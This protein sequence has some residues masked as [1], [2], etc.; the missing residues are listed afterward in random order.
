MSLEY[1]QGNQNL[2]AVTGIID[3]YNDWFGQVVTAVSY[4][5]ENNITDNVH[6][7]VSFISW[8]QDQRSDEENG[9]SSDIIE[10]LEEMHI[11]MMSRGDMIMQITSTGN[12]PDFAD[13]SD[14][15]NLFDA[16]TG[17]LRRLER[18]S[19]AEG[20]GFDEKTG[21]RNEKVMEEDLNKEMERVARNGSPF[22]I[23]Y[24]RIDRFFQFDDKDP[25]IEIVADNIKKCMRT[26][27]DAYYLGGGDFV[28]SLK[29]ADMIGA[30]AATNRLQNFIKTD[31][32]NN[33]NITLSYC[34]SEPVAGDKVDELIGN[35]KS[36]LDAY[37]GDDDVV[38]KFVEVSAL[39]RYLDEVE[40]Q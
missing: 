14:F 15:K 31:E 23:I 13:F 30:Q 24:T 17:R 5:E 9:F 8:A 20:A 21:L 39:Q 32:N 11:D 26:F 16:F 36:D 34:M 18:D 40:S 12:K 6:K 37:D 35:M 28:L 22:S 38:L 4:P 29:Q 7:P 33:S 10:N 25:V 1:E 19:M 2:E 3:D 27:D